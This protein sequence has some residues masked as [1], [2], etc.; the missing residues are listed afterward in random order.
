MASGSDMLDSYRSVV[1]AAETMLVQARNGRWDEVARSAQSVGAIT[2]SIDD[3]RR[4]TGEMRPADEAER[5]RLLARLVRIDA[6]IRA[7][8]QPWTLRLDAMLGASSRHSPHDAAAVSG[9][10]RRPR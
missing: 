10:P 4:A 5:V 8:R 3:A 6:E 2:R 9:G 1:D 7:L